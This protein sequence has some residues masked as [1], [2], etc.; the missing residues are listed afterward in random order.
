MTDSALN[1]GL[2]HPDAVSAETTTI[3]AAII[4]AM[5]PMP[6]WWEV[7][8][9]ATREARRQGR[10]P[11]PPVPKSS[12]ATGQKIPGKAGDIPVRIIAPTATPRGVYLHIHGGGWTLDAADQQDPML[13]NIADTAGLVCLSV[14][15]RLAPEH[16]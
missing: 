12:R 6:E 1:P 14:E 2:F 3:N 9:E 11:F 10:G 5:T 13:E 15:Y 8:A 4:Q 7:G 16:P